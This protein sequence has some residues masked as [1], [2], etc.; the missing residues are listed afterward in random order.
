MPN[1]FIYR[2]IIAG[3]LCFSAIV[4]VSL[5]S[6]KP[7]VNHSPAYIGIIAFAIS[8]SGSAVLSV[9]WITYGN[10]AAFVFSIILLLCASA[11]AGYTILWSFAQNL[12]GYA[13]GSKFITALLFPQ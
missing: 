4:C 6:M 5:G 11:L 1:Q 12:S 9:L 2:L 10:L 13:G 8:C 7:D 3:L